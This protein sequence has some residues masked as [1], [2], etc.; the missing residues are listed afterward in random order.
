MSSSTHDDPL[1]PLPLRG[2]PL[3]GRQR[4]ES[5][6]RERPSSEELHPASPPPE[7]GHS[8]GDRPHGERPL[9][10]RPT[11]GVPRHPAP[12]ANRDVRDSGAVPAEG[13]RSARRPCSFPGLMRILLPEQTFVPQVFAVR[14]VDLS[15]IGARLETRQ[16]THDLYLQI[17]L[18]PRFVRLEILIPS[19]EKITVSGKLV[20]LDYQEPTSTMGITI[21]PRR[22]DLTDAALPQ[23]SPRNSLDSKFLTPPRLDAY[24]TVTGK[25]KFRFSGDA[26]DADHVIVETAT[27]EIR[28]PVDDGQFH[29]DVPLVPNRP[30]G[31]H[32]IALSGE[33]SSDPTP[34]LIVHKMGHHDTQTLRQ[35]GVFNDIIVSGNGGSLKVKFAGPPNDFLQALKRMEDILGYAQSITFTAEIRGDAER[36]A[37]T[38]KR[39]GKYPF[40]PEVE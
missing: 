27:E 31:L 3:P 35:G 34:A 33:A 23:W 8:H 38:L 13:R 1:R 6:E 25:S 30:N 14:V 7:T 10:P 17:N 18:E 5:G 20:W 32:F 2:T 28:V 9:P 29:V 26:L 11:G 22:D 12:E 24:P 37:N 39:G 40:K 36:A 4:T 16:M 19:R 15:P 21:V